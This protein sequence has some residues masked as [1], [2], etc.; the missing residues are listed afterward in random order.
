[1]KILNVHKLYPSDVY[2]S[3]I[4]MQTDHL[5]PEAELVSGNI[6]IVVVYSLLLPYLYIV[7]YI[8]LVELYAD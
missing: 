1:M 4:R 8:E 3:F 7:S 2:C 5:G 6:T